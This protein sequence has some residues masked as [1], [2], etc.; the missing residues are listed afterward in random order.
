MYEVINYTNLIKNETYY[1]R[2]SQTLTYIVTYVQYACYFMMC[3]NVHLYNLK[4]K[5]IQY[6]NVPYPEICYFSKYDTYLRPVSKK[7]YMNK[8][9]EVYARNMTNTIL[10]SLI[11]RY[12]NCNFL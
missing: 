7:E 9:I 1:I 6:D 2:V 11:D 5:E 10:Q 3:K 12:F 8:L 4:K